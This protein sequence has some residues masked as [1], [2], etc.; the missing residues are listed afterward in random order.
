MIAQ[1]I[2]CWWCLDYC[3]LPTLKHFSTLRLHQCDAEG[4][5]RRHACEPATDIHSKIY[6]LRLTAW[7]LTPS[8]TLLDSPLPPPLQSLVS[9]PPMSSPPWH[10]T[11]KSWLTIILRKYIAYLFTWVYSPSSLFPPALPRYSSSPPA[12]SSSHPSATSPLSPLIS[13]DHPLLLSDAPPNSSA[14]HS[15]HFFSCPPPFCAPLS[16]PYSPPLFSNAQDF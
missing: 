11:V 10:W 15:P 3:A 13:D 9:F 7:I 4:H 14:S 1:N 12:S 8:L 5:P 6:I 16:L 2:T